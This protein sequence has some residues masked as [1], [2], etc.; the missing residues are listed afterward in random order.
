LGLRS[1]KNSAVRGSQLK[2]LGANS[3]GVACPTL[4]QGRRDA[5]DPENRLVE[6]AF[7][8]YP[9]N[10]VHAKEH[11]A[12]S[13]FFGSEGSLAM[14]NHNV[15]LLAASAAAKAGLPELHRAFD[16]GLLA[17]NLTS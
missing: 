13:A 6:L 10:G 4:K 5:G 17:S 2:S 16:S 15:E 1:V 11:L 12:T 14:V 9:G 3:T 8:R 7:D